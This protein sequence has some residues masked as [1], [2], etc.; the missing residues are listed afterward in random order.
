MN[1]LTTEMICSLMDLRDEYAMAYLEHCL[2]NLGYDNLSTIQTLTTAYS[3]EL[4]K[5]FLETNKEF[6]KVKENRTITFQHLSNRGADKP[7]SGKRFSEEFYKELSNFA[8]TCEKTEEL[9]K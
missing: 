3:Q 8:H 1:N 2:K 4:A 5:K 6:F 9:Q 7:H